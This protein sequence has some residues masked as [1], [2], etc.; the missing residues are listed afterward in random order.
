MISEYLYIALFTLMISSPLFSFFCWKIKNELSFII[1]FISLALT[2]FL[3]TF[4]YLYPSSYLKFTINEINFLFLIVNT[5]VSF[6]VSLYSYSY[7]VENKFLTAFLIYSYSMDLMLLSSDIITLYV[8][9]EISAIVSIYLIAYSKGL[10][11]EA[12]FKYYVL[13]IFSSSFIIGGI[14]FYGSDFSIPLKG[15]ANSISTI[16][17]FVGFGTKSAVFPFHAWLPDAHSEAPTPISA[18]LSGPMLN[19]GAYGILMTVTPMLP[20]INTLQSILIIIGGL[21]IFLGSSFAL[22]Q[23]DVKRALAYS[24]IGQLGCIITSFS[25]GTDIGIIAGI[26]YAMVHASTKAMLF[27]SSG[28]AVKA[29]GSRDIDKMGGLKENLPF[30]SWTFGIGAW[31][32]SGLP[33]FPGFFAKLFVFY[34]L[35]S[36]YFISLNPAAIF[37][38]V[39]AVAS[40]FLTMTYTIRRLWHGIYLGEKKN[41]NFRESGFFIVPEIILAIFI[42][43]LSV[44]PFLMEVEA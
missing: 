13:S 40:A 32:L 14:A 16:L 29:V 5:V 22:T 26:F 8:F 19:T 36:Y 38:L 10:A 11:F 12:S 43:S 30:S 25:L 28:V 33:P 37:A 31:T 3:V 21:T 9:F 1:V 42:V 15:I 35:V 39:L 7:G 6:A 23:K 34:A 2:I 4:L 17:F 20:Y 18:M 24:S 41:I 27:L 44:L